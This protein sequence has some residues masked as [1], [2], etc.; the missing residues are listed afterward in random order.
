MDYDKVNLKIVINGEIL[1]IPCNMAISP[2]GDKLVMV[3]K[4]DQVGVV[5]ELRDRIAHDGNRLE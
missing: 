2:D 5:K 3:F 4:Q 1:A